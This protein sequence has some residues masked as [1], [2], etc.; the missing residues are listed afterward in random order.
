MEPN[1][2]EHNGFLK[3]LFHHLP[4]VTLIVDKNQK[5]VFSN[6]AAEAMIPHKGF[7]HKRIGNALRCVNSEKTPGGCGESERCRTCQA[8][9]SISTAL[10]GNAVTR[11]RMKMELLKDN[12]LT[13]LPLFVT[14]APL[15][16][17]DEK[18]CLLVLEDISEIVKLRSFL[19]ICAHCKKIRNDKN[20][21]EA[22]ESYFHTHLF[23][24]NFSHS[25]CPDCEKKHYSELLS[26][27]PLS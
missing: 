22:V 24:V 7:L 10:R 23:D 17:E 21:W 4:F 9:T 18:Y 20:Y 3:N 26:N 12:E 2:I 11:T 27:E 8:R 14:A 1:P 25:I 13:E 6:A 19:P 16:F 15:A 5:I